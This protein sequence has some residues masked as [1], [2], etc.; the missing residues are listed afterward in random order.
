MI[1]LKV[2]NWLK[3]NWFIVAVA[4]IVVVIF[5]G[6]ATKTQS[7]TKILE[8]TNK[9][10]QKEIED[11][12]ASHE[13]DIK[14]RDEAINKYQESLQRIEEEYEAAKKELDNRKTETVIKIIRETGGKPEELAKA[15]SNTT[16][17]I[18]VPAKE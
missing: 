13:R 18:V 7:L 5:A 14:A 8:E 15:L 10:H 4:A 3:S 17:F 1:W 9:R 11:I 12:T 6:I 16:G 2:W